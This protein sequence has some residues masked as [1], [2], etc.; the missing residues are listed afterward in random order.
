MEEAGGLGK[1]GVGASISRDE[2][3]SENLSYRWKSV[4]EINVS[5]LLQQSLSEKMVKNFL[6][7][8]KQ[9]PKKFFFLSG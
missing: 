6:P 8:Q 5:F 9:K 2:S 1:V 7:Q 3:K 4:V